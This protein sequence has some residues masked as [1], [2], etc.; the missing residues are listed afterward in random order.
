MK[1]SDKRW[2]KGILPA[3]CLLLWG[4]EGFPLIDAAEHR[5]ITLK[6]R[7]SIKIIFL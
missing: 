5:Q 7:F 6:K 4:R 3:C 1:K 2:G